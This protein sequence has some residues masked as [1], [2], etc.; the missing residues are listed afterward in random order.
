[1]TIVSS[2]LLIVLL[3]QTLFC[4]ILIMNAPNFS[5]VFL[6]FVHRFWG[7][8]AFSL[9]PFFCSF[10]VYFFHLG[11][12]WDSWIAPFPYLSFKFKVIPK[13]WSIL[14]LISFQNIHFS[15][16]RSK[17]LQNHPSPVTH[18]KSFCK[19]YNLSVDLDK[20]RKCNL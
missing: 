19:Y 8:S 7:I 16:T 9:S 13:Y 12:S 5:D 15:F 3:R 1:L 14:S 18:L 11:K 4:G 10:F 20:T 6:G 17:S 2:V